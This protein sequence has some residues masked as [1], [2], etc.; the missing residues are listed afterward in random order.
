MS[1]CIY[2]FKLIDVYCN[3]TIV[4]RI[5]YTAY[6][7]NW[8]KNSYQLSERLA[9]LSIIVDQLRASPPQELKVASFHELASVNKLAEGLN[10][11]LI[12][13]LFFWRIYTRYFRQTFIRICEVKKTLTTK[14][15]E[16]SWNWC[17]KARV[18][19]ACELELDRGRYVQHLL[20]ERL[21]LSA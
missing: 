16:S 17:E 12:V 18:D 14:I 11:S 3:F 10:A 7:T 13:R 4:P 8:R 1:P 19:N 20:S 21:R 6:K 15:H 9:S 2:S 5:N